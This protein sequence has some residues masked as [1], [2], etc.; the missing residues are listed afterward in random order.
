MKN[1]IKFTAAGLGGF[2]AG[3]GLMK[4]KILKA[5][6]KMVKEEYESK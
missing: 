2:L 3:Y 1:V 5:F 6:Y 4:Y